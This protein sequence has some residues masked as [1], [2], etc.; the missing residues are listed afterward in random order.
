MRGV[1]LSFNGL[2]VPGIISVEPPVLVGFEMGQNPESA[3]L[4]AVKASDI[5]P[6]GVI[7]GVRFESPNG[8]YRV[9]RIDSHPD[10]V[11][12]SIRAVVDFVDTAN[13]LTD[14]SGNVLTDE[15]GFRLSP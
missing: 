5:A 14:E 9:T 8:R 10:A 3:V 11:V 6:L 15:N 13:V 4:V 12:V 2:P 7:E 1:S